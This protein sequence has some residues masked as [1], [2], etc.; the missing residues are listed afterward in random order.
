MS[1]DTPRPERV[2]LTDEERAT[3][4]AAVEAVEGECICEHDALADHDSAGCY[5]VASYFPLVRCDCKRGHGAVSQ[6]T[7]ESVVTAVEDTLAAREQALREEIGVIAA[8]ALTIAAA[9]VRSQ[10]EERTHVVDGQ[11]RHLSTIAKG[12][13]QRLARIARGETR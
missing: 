10:G 9:L 13:H 7:F 6:R 2:T 8:D 3:I 12:I 4:L 11:K 5:A 1:T